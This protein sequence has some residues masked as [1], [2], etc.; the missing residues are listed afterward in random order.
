MGVENKIQINGLYNVSITIDEY[1]GYQNLVMGIIRFDTDN[2][3]FNSRE[4][5]PD[6]IPPHL[7]TEKPSPVL[8][9]LKEHFL[10]EEIKLIRNYLKTFDGAK[11]SKPCICHIPENGVV[12][13]IAWLPTS[14][15]YEFY[16][17]FDESDYS[18]PFKI[19]GYIDL[20]SEVG[21]E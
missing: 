1:C 10:I 19:T 21:G 15:D 17:F 9:Y 12:Y 14:K 6:Y 20:N 16:L 3:P 5:L 11:V 18:L 7:L 2:V 8:E 4:F 13:P